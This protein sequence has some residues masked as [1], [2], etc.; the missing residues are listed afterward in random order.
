MG[1]EAIGLDPA[2]CQAFTDKV[3]ADSG[4]SSAAAALIQRLSRT[5]ISSASRAS[6]ALS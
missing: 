5:V 3:K 6:I 2:G 1:G 4:G